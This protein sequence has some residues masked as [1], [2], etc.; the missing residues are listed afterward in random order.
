M[1]ALTGTN[2]LEAFMAEAQTTTNPSFYASYGITDS[3]EDF[4]SIAP[5]SGSLSGVTPVTLVAAPGG[6][7]LRHDVRDLTIFNV[8]TIDHTITLRVDVSGGKFNVWSGSIPTGGFARLEN[9]TGRIVIYNA[10]GEETSST[11]GLILHANTHQHGGTDEVATGSPAANAI[12]KADGTG[13]FADG[14]V[15]ESSVTQHEGAIDHDALTGFVLDEHRPLDDGL[16]TTTNLWSASKIQSELLT[17]SDFMDAFTA[18]QLDTPGGTDWAV[19]VAAPAEQDDNNAALVIRSFDDT[20]EEG[21]G[22]SVSIPA[23]STE[24][25]LRFKGRA[26]TGPPGTR[27]VGLKLYTRS[28]PDN[29]T[30]SAWSA[31][32]VLTDIDIPL[33]ENF[34]YAMQTFTLAA[35]GLSANTLYQF[36]ITRIAPTGGTNLVGDW[37]AAEVAVS[38]NIEDGS[39]ITLYSADLMFPTNADWAVNAHAVEAADS[40]NDALI[41]RRFDDASEEGVGLVALVPSTASQITFRFKSR[42]ET[43]PPGVRGV[44]PRIYTRE[45]PD[46]TAPTSWSAGLDMTTLDM[47]TNENFQYDEQTLTLAALGVAAGRLVQIEITR[48]P[49]DA[50]DDLVGDWALASLQIVFT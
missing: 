33:N 35:L 41:V 5:S 31:G 46:N 48:D 43:S 39:T 9:S 8:D 29:A 32:T 42:A 15:S 49:L 47:P 44:V 50:S 22:F 1:I 45:F 12:P 6:G 4:A 34:Q 24:V 18:D 21:V 16:T 30:P 7:N 28:F 20:A 38:F 19:N 25:T 17:S 11:T 36:E 40:N 2:F 26:R 13:K 23:G 37:L 27:T 3:L 10:V 14:W